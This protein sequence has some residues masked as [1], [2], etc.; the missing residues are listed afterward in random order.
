M[1]RSTPDETQLSTLPAAVQ[2]GLAVAWSPGESLVAQAELDLDGK[3]NFGR[4][5]LVLSSQRLHFF[6][7]QEPNGLKSWELTPELAMRT[8]L[9]AGLGAA[10]LLAGANLV[11]TWNY[12]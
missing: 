2:A 9:H 4:S 5:F 12:T 11:Q 8:S 10:R 6:N 7:P 1:N 3:Q